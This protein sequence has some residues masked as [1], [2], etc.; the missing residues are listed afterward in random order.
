[1]QLQ[2]WPGDKEPTEVMKVWQ[3]LDQQNRAA[4][5]AALARLM[6]R[7]ISSSNPSQTKEEKHES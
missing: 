2:L 4:I 3:N 7:V 5:V 6:V 1:M